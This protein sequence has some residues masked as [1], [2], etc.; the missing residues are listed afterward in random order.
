MRSLVPPPGLFV[1][2]RSTSQSCVPR[3]FTSIPL[4]SSRGHCSRLAP[5]RLRSST[6]CQK[7]GRPKAWSAVASCERRQVLNDRSDRSDGP[8]L[9]HRSGSG[10]VL[11]LCP[12]VAF[13]LPSASSSWMLA[14]RI[15]R[16]VNRWP[17]TSLRVEL[18]L[19][20]SQCEQLAA[21]SPCRRSSHRLAV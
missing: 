15:P 20:T 12:V 1:L 6:N 2:G 3:M 4:R 21:A 13:S 7:C 18:E 16:S 5:E 14:Y 10:R 9:S 17:R 19:R 8:L 11:P